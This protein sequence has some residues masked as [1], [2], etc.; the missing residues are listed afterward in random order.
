M[1]DHRRWMLSKKNENWN[2]IY[3]ITMANIYIYLIAK[4]YIYA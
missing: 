3:A 4:I 1:E 2:Y